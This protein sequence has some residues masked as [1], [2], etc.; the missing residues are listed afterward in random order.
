MTTIPDRIHAA[1]IDQA[2]A[3]ARYEAHLQQQVLDQL[4]ALEE[5]LLT[6]L[7][8][9]GLDTPRTD[10][11]RAR[12]QRLLVAVE[13]QILEGYQGISD[14]TAGELARLAQATSDSLVDGL[15]EAVRVDL[16]QTAG[17]TM[18]EW[19]LL[20]GATL[21]QGAPSAD[22]WTRQGEDL[23]QAFADQMRQGMQRGETVQELA[24]RVKG[25]RTAPGLMDVTQRNA[26][27]LVRTSVIS[28]SNAAHLE[29][30]RK[31]GDLVK[32]IQWV[33]T[34]DTRTTPICQA[35]DGMMW[36][37]DGKPIDGALPFPGPTAHWGCRSTQVPVLKSWEDLARETGGDTALARKLDQMPKGQRA[38]MS[39]PV[40]GDLTYETWFEGLSPAKQRDILGPA[41]YDIWRR[42]NLSFRDMVNQRGNPLTVE[43]LRAK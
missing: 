25:T 29:T 32:G 4:R 36:D 23:A 5:A 27:A 14:L 16:F 43:Q 3:E 12:M 21:V 24:Q 19:R 42:G 30:Y 22:W 40:S 18:A 35:L 41:K 31:N 11:Q 28:V 38:S 10:W 37:L 17:T 8:G 20:V 15:N 9:A 26:E 39:G 1:L 34:L 6:A 33:S 7:N 2:V 13:R